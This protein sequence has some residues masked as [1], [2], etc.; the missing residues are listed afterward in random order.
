[1]P[2]SIRAL[3]GGL[4]IGR[5]DITIRRRLLALIHPQEQAIDLETLGRASSLTTDLMQSRSR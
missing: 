5:S 4:R 2:Y 1:M 3:V